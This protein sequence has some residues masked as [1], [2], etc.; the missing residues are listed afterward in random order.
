MIKNKFVGICSLLCSALLIQG[1]TT[2]AIDSETTGGQATAKPQAAKNILFIAVDDLRPEL[3][4]F[5]ASHI[6][7]P[8]IDALASQS[9][10]F[11]NHFVNSP[12]CGSSR[13]TLL[14]GRY[15]PNGN[16]AL[17]AR[18]K[19]MAKAAGQVPISMPGW[20]KEQGYTTISVGKVSHYPGGQMGE[21]WN[22]E[23]QL[24]MPDAWTKAVMPVG[25]WQTPKGMMHGLA[26]GEIRVKPSDMD[27]FQAAEG[28]DNIY[29]DGLITDEAIKQLQQLTSNPK[30]PFFL[31]VGI[32]RPH[33]PFG[34]PKK[35]LD[36]YKDVEFPQN[37]FPNKPE[38][39][40]TWHPSGEFKRY[41]HWGK[42]PVKD[43]A[44]ADEV[45]RHYAASVSYADAQVGKILQALKAS[46]ADKNTI[47]VLWGDHGWNLGEHAIWGKHNLYEEALRAPLLI[48]YPDI[49]N[50][51]VSTK[52]VVETTDIFPTLA[53]LTG[54][55]FAEPTH[56]QALL[57][58]INTAD[59]P[60]HAAY[61]Y[62]GRNRTL[63]MDNFRL[64]LFNN[65]AV[66]LYD[67]NSPEK[68]TKNVASQHPEVVDKM[69]KVLQNKMKLN[70]SF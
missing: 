17:K 16:N 41:N 21:H 32:I 58:Q 65:K 45:R 3:N 23:S 59:K 42:D 37:P 19:T 22:D 43:K 15:G 9:R 27:V 52:A 69:L 53:K 24:E 48:S 2:S 30:N 29:P 13:Y 12:S 51:G 34:A 66:A 4:S 38:G 60:G 5:G 63:R 18:A 36:L 20:F 70:D 68:E 46:G 10:I 57:E 50:P 1:C 55:S 6:H 64:T 47:V 26:H 8:N 35:Y 39:L 25:D 49:P 56:G 44:F 28:D 54:L 14:T 31:A 33:L 11:L 61:A 67:L 62:W 40:S 7:S